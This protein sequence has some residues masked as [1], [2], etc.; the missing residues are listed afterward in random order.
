MFRRLTLFEAPVTL[1]AAEPTEGLML[2]HQED[3]LGVGTHQR[4]PVLRGRHVLQNGGQRGK[5]LTERPFS[6]AQ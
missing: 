6:A 4:G 1:L 3:A 2:V 5:K